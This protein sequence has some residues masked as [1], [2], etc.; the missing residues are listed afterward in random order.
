MLLSREFMQLVRSHLADGGA[1][2]FNSTRSPDAH[3]TASAVFS[4]VYSF[5]TFVVA[6]DRQLAMDFDVAAHQLARVNLPRG[7]HVNT[8]DPRVAAKI[9]SMVAEFRP[10]VPIP[11]AQVITGRPC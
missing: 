11:G 8:G 2:A 4:N 5:E 9:T 7:R 3:A 1:Y 6:S 10:Y